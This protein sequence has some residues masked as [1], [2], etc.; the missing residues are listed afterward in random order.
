MNNSIG[1]NINCLVNKI[2]DDYKQGS[3]VD[4]K[5]TFMRPK[6]DTIVKIIVQ[7]RNIIFPEY[8]K[9]SNYRV[10]TIRNNLSMQLEDVMY[11]LSKQISIVLKYLPEH[12]NKSD[13]ELLTEAEQ[14]TLKFLDR[15][16]EIRRLI[17]TDL[18]AAYD[19]DPAAFNKPEIVFSYPGLFA[20]LV[21]RIAHELYLLNVPL[22]PRIMTEYAHTQTGI[23]I[24]PGATIGEYFFIDHGTGIVVGETSVIGNNVKIY[25]GVT[26][27][28]LSTRE[29]QKLH[30]TRRHPT[31]ED[32]VTIYAG[33]SI[34]G[35]NTVIGRNSVI[36]SNVFIT[37]SIPPDTRVSIKTQELLMKS[38]SRKRMSSEELVQDDKW[39][40][41]I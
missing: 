27:G 17:N 31:I 37:T 5:E 40:Y 22:I 11:N 16:T 21:S 18:E 35:G 41:E 33:A 20:I 38:G 28:A 7:L 4:I 8:F 39:C 29:G 32:N 36:G 24:H 12:E 34:L 10:Y 19:G 30:G 25:Q 3:H 26:I 9:N 15:L 23:D 13:D 1:E 14:L 6:K 2:I